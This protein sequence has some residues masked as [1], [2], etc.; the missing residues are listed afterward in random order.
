[1]SVQVKKKCGIY[2]I[3]DGNG[4]K[5]GLAVDIDQRLLDLQTGNSRK[6]ILLVHIAIPKEQLYSEENKT[7]KY[8]EK[9]HLQGEWYSIS[10]EQAY[11]YTEKRT[12]AIINEV[13]KQERRTPAKVSTL[14]G[15]E[16]VRESIPPCFFYPDQSAHSYFAFGAPKNSHRKIRY[17]GVRPDHPSYAGKDK[18]DGVSQVYVSGKWW[19]EH[20]NIMN[21][22]ADDALEKRYKKRTKKCKE[23]L[24]LCQSK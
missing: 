10:Q 16:S 3:S 9:Y 1:M 22:M 19:K 14:F 8:F 13:V 7:H 18:R 15:V 24:V 11:E 6:L 20:R 23:M 21:S 17:K 12:D 5:I 2:F 4:I